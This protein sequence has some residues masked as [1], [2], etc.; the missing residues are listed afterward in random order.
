MERRTHAGAQVNALVAALAQA[1]DAVPAGSYA[2]VVVPDHL[3]S[4]PFARNAQGG[5]MLPPVQPRS[6]S[7]Q[8]IVQLPADLPSWPG[9]LEKNIIGRLMNG[10]LGEVTAVPGAPGTSMPLSLPDRY[11]CW[12]PSAQALVALPL[13]FEPGFHDWEA[14][15]TRALDTAGCR[16]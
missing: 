10:P 11:F 2:F 4:I 3:G 15:W 12:S 14:V 8:L 6:L 1:A 5:L 7:A 16:E 13:S 9:L